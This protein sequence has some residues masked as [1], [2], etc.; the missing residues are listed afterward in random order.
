MVAVITHHCWGS[1]SHPRPRPQFELQKYN[2]FTKA[3]IL[4]LCLLS[5]L[6]QPF[7][8]ISFL[9]VFQIFWTVSISTHRHLNPLNPTIT[10]VATTHPGRNCR[11]RKEKLVLMVSHFRN[12]ASAHQSVTGIE[13]IHAIFF[14]KNIDFVCEPQRSYFQP[15]CNCKAKAFLLQV[16][17]FELENPS[18]IM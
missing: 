1:I 14:Y 6:F 13:W 12:L 16:F 18:I 3:N 8:L 10:E 15:H 17:I 11:L 5:N 9:I 4:C 7:Q 2:N